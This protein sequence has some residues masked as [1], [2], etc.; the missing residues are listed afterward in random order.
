MAVF[1]F[2]FD[3]V[4]ADTLQTEI[5]YFL[6]ISK[7]NNLGISS[8][9][10]LVSLCN[11]NVFKSLHARGISIPLYL[12]AYNE[13]YDVL[14][15]EK[16]ITKPF[17][18]MIALLK[19]TALK[20]PVYIV[21]SNIYK[22]PDDMLSKYKITGIRGI[23]SAETENSKVKKINS[24]KEKYPNDRI[25]F[26]TDTKGDV[27][28][29]HES[30]ADIVVAVTWGWHSRDLLETSNADIIIDS[31]LELQEYIGSAI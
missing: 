29:A 30:A 2:D 31:V 12:Q 10:D 3:G 22:F 19:E 11:E 17:P 26:I 15:K 27:I 4:I 16:Y 6:P 25:Y 9:Q 21:T 7:K 28:E 18:G 14:S 1:L 23:L 5:K 8:V 20:Y 24:V 13:F